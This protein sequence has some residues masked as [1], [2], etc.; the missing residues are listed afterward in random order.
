MLPIAL[1]L[2]ERLQTT[3]MLFMIALGLWGLF[4]YFRNVDVTDGYRGALVIG[5]LLIISEA[6][7]GLYLLPSHG[8]LLPRQ[9]IHILYGITCVIALPGAFAYTRGRDGRWEG[10]AY[11]CVCLFV[12]GLSIRLQHIA[13][14]QT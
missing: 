3:V 5:E 12:A 7:I 9:S 13:T 14:I 10:L 4:N 2:H 11:A 1:I 6:L 8:S